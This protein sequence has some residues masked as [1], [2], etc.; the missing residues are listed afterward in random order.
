MADKLRFQVRYVLAGKRWVWGVVNVPSLTAGLSQEEAEDMAAQLNA[1]LAARD[2]DGA[3]RRRCAR[4]PAV[5]TQC[6]QSS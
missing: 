6:L 1:D 2:A 5:G 3:S 4:C